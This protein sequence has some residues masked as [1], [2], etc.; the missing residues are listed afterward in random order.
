MEDN[1]KYVKNGRRHQKFQK[2]K[3][4]SKISKLE[5]DLNSKWKMK[6]NNKSFLDF[7]KI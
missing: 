1:L 2:W 3:T 5:D 6:T 4:T 7:S